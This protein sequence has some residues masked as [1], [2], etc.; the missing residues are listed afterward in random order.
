MT[1]MNIGINIKLSYHGA[2]DF[3]IPLINNDTINKILLFRNDKIDEIDKIHNIS[4]KYL[5]QS[6][7]I[8]IIKFVKM[9]FTINGDTKLLIGFYEIP[10]GLYAVLIGK[11]KNIPSVVCFLSNIEYKKV[12]KGFRLW[13]TLWILKKAN[14][15]TVTGSVSREK[16]IKKG[17]DGNKILILPNPVNTEIN[18]PLDML[19]KF[20][21]ITL[22]NLLP[23]KRID[24]LIKCI[25]KLKHFYPNIQVGIAGVGPEYG[26]LILLV[27]ELELQNNIH[28]MG[29]V[30]NASEFYNLGKIFVLTSESEGLPR[31]ILEAMACGIPCL[32]VRVGDVAD[33]VIDSVNGFVLSNNIYDSFNE[34]VSILLR[35]KILYNEFS[36]NSRKTVVDKY[37]YDARFEFWD[38]FINNIIKTK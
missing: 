22:T 35:N 6:I 36:V 3:L 27:N 38:N 2:I 21:I 32:T 14:Y 13:L 37:G 31:T 12:R 17:I 28:F 23:E 8:E 30:E 25:E 24:I 33:V 29:F 20:D 26:K 10:H 18:K 1:K 5:N 16:L 4:N 7:L 15:V 11:I 19:K 9:V 34:K